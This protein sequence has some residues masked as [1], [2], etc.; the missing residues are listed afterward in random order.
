MYEPHRV[1]VVESL[2]RVSPA[3]RRRALA[4]AGWN[5]FQL[6][7]GLVE[8]DL[9]SDSGTGAMSSRQWAA[10]AAARED[11]SGQESYENFVAAAR[12]VFGFAHIQPVHQGRAAEN[13]LFR[14]LLERG[15]VVLSN[16]FFETTRSN[17]E[18][19][20]CEARDL[21]A[22]REPWC[23]DIDLDRLERTLGRNR[24]VALIVLTVTNNIDG[25]QPVAIDTIRRARELADAHGV[26][27]A[28]DASRFAGNAYL[29]KEL[30]GSRKSVK[31]LCREL[32]EPAHLVYLSCKKDALANVGGVIAFDDDALL[33]P[34][35]HEMIR[36]ESYPS[37]GGLAAR[38]LAAMTVGLEEAV[39]D[40]VVA[41]HVESV[42]R[43]AARLESQGVAV[44]TPVGAHGVVIRPRS[45]DRH[46]P[47]ALAAA[48]Y[49]EGAVRAAVFG[50]SVRLAPPRRV[51]TRDHLEHV[52][53]VVGQAW[54][55]PLPRLRCVHRPEEFFNFF[56]RFEPVEGD[57]DAS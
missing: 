1:K 24:R 46:G 35:L 52:A 9:V 44:G 10:M 13:L 43:L 33:R 53:A 41:S 30:T 3:A 17:I 40:R 51:Y 47:H 14:L 42:R 29:V 48:I 55:R 8:I 26:L 19:L 57:H 36:Q 2:P 18:V 22:D 56:A 32:F 6:A 25:G 38:D 50:D 16:T 4:A 11:F 49:L 31:R 23:G 34:M 28:L 5:T 15:D 20:G 12:D 7:A 54:R 37:A 27:L 39:D 21:P 45:D